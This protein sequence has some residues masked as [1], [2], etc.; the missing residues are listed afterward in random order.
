M[1]ALK[2]ALSD[3]KFAFY[4]RE[5]LYRKRLYKTRRSPEHCISAYRVYE[6]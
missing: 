4:S 6:T 1:G 2:C 3:Q 5:Q